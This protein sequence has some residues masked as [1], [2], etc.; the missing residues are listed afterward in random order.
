MSEQIEVAPIVT[1]Y[2]L[3]QETI[4]TQQATID[5]LTDQRDRLVR[6]IKGSGLNGHD[7]VN[8]ANKLIAEIEAGK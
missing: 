5:R 2:S 1:A 6:Y 8:L 3:A 4:R 7:T